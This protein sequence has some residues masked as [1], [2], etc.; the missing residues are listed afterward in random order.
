MDLDLPI[1]GDDL[2]EGDAFVVPTE[3]QNG[4]DATITEDSSSTVAVPQQRK[5]RKPRTIPADY[6]MELHNKDLADWNTNYL[7][8]MAEASRHKNQYRTAT[9]AKKNAE[10]W[11]WGAGIGGVGSI[12]S[13]GPTPFGMF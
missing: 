4:E 9:Q 3:R 11:V 1:L 8:N 7:Q 13:T 10:F 6:T 12:G 2:P 5:Q